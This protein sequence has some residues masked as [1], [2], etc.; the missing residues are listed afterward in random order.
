M[1]NV[2]VHFHCLIL[3]SISDYPDYSQYQTQSYDQSQIKYEEEE[4]EEEEKYQIPDNTNGGR[5][6]NYDDYEEGEAY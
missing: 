4:E 3:L 6:N 1:L 5:T 2:Q